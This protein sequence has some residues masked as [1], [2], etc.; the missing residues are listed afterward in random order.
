MSTLLYL[1]PIHWDIDPRIF[2]SFEYLRWYGFSWAI[3]VYMAFLLMRYLYQKE[4]KAVESLDGLAI[5]LLIGGILGARLGHILF[6]D[7]AYY[8]EHPIEILPFRL[9]PEFQFTGFQG[10]ASHGGI[11]GAMLALGLYSWRHRENYL[12]LI[13][14][15]V[16]VVVLLGGCIRLGNLMNSEI[17]GKPSSVPWAFVFSRVDD[18]P[19]HP[20]QLYEALFYF[21]ISILLFQLWRKP[22][23][24]ARRGF[25]FG[26]GLALIFIQRFI[27]EFFKADQVAFE[28][29]MVINMGQILSIP[30]ILIGL[31]VLFKS[32]PKIPQTDA[33]DSSQS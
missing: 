8:M 28:S 2:P 7:L 5:Y 15:L 17:I 18:L 1:S 30:L 32:K 29:D 23:L 33:E 21:G 9:E 26:L 14:R 27:V 12:E 19:R 4:G 6:Y 11:F 10:L 16:I 24:A 22:H 20:A 31:I 13:D 25:L 3:G